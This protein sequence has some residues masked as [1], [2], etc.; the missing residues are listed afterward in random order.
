MTLQELLDTKR[1][2][3]DRIERDMLGIS[4]TTFTYQKLRAQHDRL[5]EDIHTLEEQREHERRV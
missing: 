1:L 3:A 2:E 4:P 5:I